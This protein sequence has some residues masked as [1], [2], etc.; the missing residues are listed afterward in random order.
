VTGDLYRHPELY[1]WAFSH[2]DVPREVEAILRWHDR[3]GPKRRVRLALELGAGP[4]NHG[5]ELARRGITV[6]ALDGSSPMRAAARANARAAGVE[7][8]VAEGDLTTFSLPT[9]FD[10]AVCA[11]DSAA[12]LLDLDALVAHLARVGHHLAAGAIYVIETAHPADFMGGTTR[13]Q[14]SWQ[15]TR[16]GRRLRV[17]WGGADDHFDPVTQIEHSTVTLTV[18][19]AKGSSPRVIRDHLVL[20]RW[21]LTEIDAAARLSGQ[22]RLTARYGDY[23]GAAL[24]D[25]GAS[26]L[27]AVL[28][29]GRH[30]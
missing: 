12:H 22:F 23:A 9:T 21:T 30:R 17:R 20:R 14:R 8:E 19:G 25:R 24:E 11:G 18:T 13:T 29:K 7:L 3:H 27:V 26:R 15:V 16:D 6:T 4:A 1:E 5:V 2:R 28:S 10:L